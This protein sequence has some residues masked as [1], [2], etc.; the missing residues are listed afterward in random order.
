MV[1]IILA[2]L[3]GIVIGASFMMFMRHKAAKGNAIYASGIV[4]EFRDYNA[5]LT[6]RVGQ[7]GK[8]LY[9]AGELLDHV[10]G[11]LSNQMDG[12]AEYG[13]D[14]MTIG[15]LIRRIQPSN[16]SELEQIDLVREKI[17]PLAEK[18]QVNP[19]HT[20]ECSL[21]HMFYIAE[22]IIE[23]SLGRISNQVKA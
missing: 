7:N 23:Q 19:I 5:I 2:L 12:Y 6:R 3:F 10:G 17:K 18:Y 15:N 8:A 9:Y 13:E 21:V 20:E 16:Y 4:K 14:L 11:T 1:I 22:Q